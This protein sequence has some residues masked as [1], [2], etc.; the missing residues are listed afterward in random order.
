MQDAL[1]MIQSVGKLTGKNLEADLLVG[2][3]QNSLS[4][5]KRH[6]TCSV[7]YLIWKSPRMAA[8]KQT[9]SDS[10]LSTIG[11]RNVAE[12]PRYPE[13]S[14]SQIQT[15]H[16][17]VVFLSSEPYQFKDRHRLGFVHFF[18]LSVPRLKKSIDSTGTSPHIPAPPP[19]THRI[20][21]HNQST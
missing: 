10:M 16:R 18:F 6:A 17:A 21:C 8:G 11:L 19:L 20:S 1:G 12:K 15:L 2:R 9:F 5:I 7:L 13:L 3:I 14:D 4:S